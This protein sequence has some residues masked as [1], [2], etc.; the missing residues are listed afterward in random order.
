M[1]RNS[2]YR[3]R[4]GLSLG[5][6]ALVGGL[7]AVRVQGAAVSACDNPKPEWLAC[8]DFEAGG[9]GWDAW[10]AGSPFVECV[11]CPNG[12]AD[13]ARIRLNQ[14]AAGAHGGEWALELPA[15]ASAG[16][17]GAS[18]TY[19]SCATQKRPGCRLTGYEE[20][21]FR[22]WVKLADDHQY[23]HHFLELAGTRPGAYW[24]SDGNAGC[25]PNGTRWAGTALDFNREHK[26]FFYTYFPEMRCDRGGYCS[27]DYAR[28][29]CTQ[30]ATK[31]MAC[32]AEPE[33]CWGNLFA[34]AEPVELPR[35]E[36]VC[37]EMSMRLNTPRQADGSMKFWVNDTLALD[38]GGMHWRDVADLQL[39]KAWLQHYIAAGDA[40]QSNRAWFDDVVVSTERIGCGVAPE[41]PSPT[42]TSTATP[43][44]TV[45]AHPTTTPV[46]TT[47][48]P[49]RW[50]VYL[51][52]SYRTVTGR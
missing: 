29:I 1:P 30:C 10:F 48:E 32:P 8:E 36:W 9:L 49:E 18:L 2:P 11:G 14:D 15:A 41:V 23:V 4:L 3:R 13:P 37:L 17:Q 34:P 50:A 26:F 44:P 39:N 52:W 47:A 38:Q 21:Y 27:G 42:A 5:L 45:T 7:V 51:P 24:E 46:A 20:L 25:R 22:T 6:L 40:Q 19:R 35:G 12:S 31:D 43:M 16:Y 28:Q 33:C